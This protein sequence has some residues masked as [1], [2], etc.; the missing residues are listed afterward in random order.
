[1]TTEPKDTQAPMSGALAQA[2]ARHMAAQAAFDAG[3]DPE[4]YQHLC[5]AEN[6]ALDELAFTPCA[7]D[8]E[9]LEKLRY[10]LAHETRIAEGPPDGSQH[11]GSI[12]IA[13]DRHFHA[14]RSLDGG[15]AGGT[16]VPASPRVDGTDVPPW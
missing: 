3:P 6:E 15:N 11:F 1:M 9:F 5:N 4:D 12:L 14:D 10:L 16:F 2:L 13:V 8:A 7:S